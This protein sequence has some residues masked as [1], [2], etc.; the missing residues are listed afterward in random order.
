MAEQWYRWILNKVL[1]FFCY[2]WRCNFTKLAWEVKDFKDLDTHLNRT[3]D[4]QEAM[5]RF[6]QWG[7]YKGLTA[8]MAAA[9]SYCDNSGFWLYLPCNLNCLF[10]WGEHVLILMSIRFLLPSLCQLLNIDCGNPCVRFRGKK[11]GL[12]RR[13]ELYNWVNFQLVLVKIPKW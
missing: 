11:I 2:L 4:S 1:A 9:A 3:R 8:A 10:L 6:Q 7:P 13:R 12:V 5:S